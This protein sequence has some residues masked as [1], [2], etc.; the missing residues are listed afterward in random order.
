MAVY[1]HITENNLRN[2]LKKYDIG[3]LIE[4]KEILEGIDNTNY[5]IKTSTNEFILTIFEKRLRKEDLP[6]FIQLQKHLI[7]KGFVCPHPIKNKNNL[8][9]N[10][11]SKKPCIIMSFLKGKK[12]KNI[13]LKHCKQIGQQL[14]I[15][16][17]ET[18]DFRLKRNNDLHQKKWSNLFDKIK[19]S[20]NNKY[21]H[22]FKEI[23]NELIFLDK[24]WPK[25]LPK[26]IIHADVFKDNVFFI[27]NIFSGIIDFYF[28]CNDFYTYEIAICINEWCFKKNNTIDR[29]KL[30]ILLNEYNKY[31]KLSKKEKDSLYILL[32]G[33]AMRIL[34]TRLH[35]AIYQI[36]GAYVKTKNP[37]KYYKIM[38]Y[39][40]KNDLIKKLNL[41]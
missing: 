2:F 41:K 19:I 11:I 29:K 1:T 18:K 4:F 15:M 39:H 32:R 36:K 7:N 17:K 14:A 37:L 24:K 9:I 35:D 16:H 3:N 23:N 20:K 25:N 12:V 28:A 5:K 21:N 40:Q 10:F 30:I 34:L 22:L 13:L 27:N 6:F 38:K 26:G 33:A 31:R 8:Y